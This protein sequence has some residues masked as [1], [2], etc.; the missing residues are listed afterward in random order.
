MILAKFFCHF[1]TLFGTLFLIFIEYIY[2]ITCLPIVVWII[3]EC[4]LLCMFLL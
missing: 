3:L 2:K 4:E 1:Q